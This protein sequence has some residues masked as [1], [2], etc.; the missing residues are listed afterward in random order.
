MEKQYYDY[1]KS[2]VTKIELL[3][4]ANHLGILRILIR[5]NEEC[6]NENKNGIYV[7]LSEVNQ[8]TIQRIQKYL[9]YIAFQEQNLN[10]I[11]SMQEDVKNCYIKT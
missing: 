6:I 4:K 8:E 5:D 9:D 10:T 11:E 3:K 1:L 2:I 7:N